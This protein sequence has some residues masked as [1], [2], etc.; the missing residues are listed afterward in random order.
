[1]R[2]KKQLKSPQEMAEGY[3]AESDGLSGQELYDL[4]TKVMKAG[5]ANPRDVNLRKEIGSITR[6]LRGVAA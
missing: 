2:L 6:S 5:G 1:M 4:L 3:L